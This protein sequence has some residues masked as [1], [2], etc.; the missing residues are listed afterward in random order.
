MLALNRFV[1]AALVLLLP[2]GLR[3]L[4][5]RTDIAEDW[6]KSPEASTCSPDPGIST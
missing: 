5:P 2:L 1:L 3:A 6:S 4:P